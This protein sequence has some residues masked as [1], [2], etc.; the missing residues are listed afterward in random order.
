MET[1]ADQ[2]ITSAD[3]DILADEDNSLLPPLP[4]LPQR[5]RELIITKRYWRKQYEKS[6]DATFK[7]EYYKYK[8]AVRKEIQRCRKKLQN[9]ASSSNATQS[10]EASTTP[11]AVVD[12]PQFLQSI[13]QRRINAMTERLKECLDDGFAVIQVL[14]EFSDLT[15]AF[16]Q[17]GARS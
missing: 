2:S 9:E 15:E 10:S 12:M 14:M 1:S 5:I 11:A 6:Y 13:D 8:R 3:V 7:Q 4:Y 16:T 17:H